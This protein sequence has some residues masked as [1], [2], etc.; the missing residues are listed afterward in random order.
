MDNFVNAMNRHTDRKV[1]IIERLHPDLRQFLP[2]HLAEPLLNVILHNNDIDPKDSRYAYVIFDPLHSRW[3]NILALE[4]YM[5]PITEEWLPRNQIEC[6]SLITRIQQ[7]FS[8]ISIELHTK[9]TVVQQTPSP[10]WK[11]IHDEYEESRFALESIRRRTRLVSTEISAKIMDFE[12]GNKELAEEFTRNFRNE[13]F[14]NTVN[15]EI[16][17]FTADVQQIRD[18]SRYFSS[19]MWPCL[20]LKVD[21]IDTTPKPEWIVYHPAMNQVWV[22][23]ESN[24]DEFR[25]LWKMVVK[26]HTLAMTYSVFGSVVIR[27]R[28]YAQSELEYL[29]INFKQDGLVHSS[30]YVLAKFLNFA[31][32]NM[33]IAAIVTENIDVLRS[34]KDQWINRT[35]VIIQQEMQQKNLL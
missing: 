22:W 32:L 25:L 12:Q 21:T 4:P 11:S 17:R 23:W 2:G 34:V 20:K 14:S 19:V 35:A 10:G 7:L 29:F 13:I 26:F 15:P 9:E 33:D 28:Q 1:Q 8:R 18:Y 5:H 30:L 3:I 24:I 16:E 27:P 6:K 31:C